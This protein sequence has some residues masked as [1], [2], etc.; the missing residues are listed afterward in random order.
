MR[1]VLLIICFGLMFVDSA[2]AEVLATLGSIRTSINR[3]FNKADSAGDAIFTVARVNT[4]I[5]R[6]IQQVSNDFDAV[7]KMD[8]IATDPDTL[9]YALNSDF[10][11]A[12]W[13]KD[14]LGETVD[15]TIFDKRLYLTPA[16]TEGNVTILLAYYA[17]GTTLTVDT[18]TT[19]ILP[20]YREAMIAWASYLL[21]QTRSK[22]SDA[23]GYLTNY[24]ELIAIDRAGKE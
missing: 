20:E 2:Q 17:L 5:N 10:L 3:Q 23:Q 15:V 4:A 19:D 21:S 22:P 12:A 9:S 13:S 24:K 11:R 16:Q 7:P 1:K 14:Y 18:N 6:G 8:T